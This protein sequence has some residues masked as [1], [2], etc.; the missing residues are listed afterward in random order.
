MTLE[1]GSFLAILEIGELAREL[2]WMLSIRQVNPYPGHS[3][4]DGL[5]TYYPSLTP[6]PGPWTKGTG[7][8][9][10]GDQGPWCR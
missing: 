5:K 2:V 3:L 1:L 9:G 4:Q 8:E 10:K 6:S 7:G